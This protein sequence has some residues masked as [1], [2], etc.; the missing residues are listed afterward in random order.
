MKILILGGT[1]FLGRQ[2]ARA[3]LNAGHEVT[4][5]NRGQ[6]NP[7]LFRDEA[8][9]IHGD[10]DG[11]LDVLNGRVFDACIDPSG[12]IPRHVRDSVELMKDVVD[13]YTFISSIS[14]HPTFTR[15]QDESAPLAEL[16]DETVETMDE[17]NYGGLKVLCEQ[18]AEELM[19]GRVLHVRS[20]LIIGPYDPTD[21]FSYW[22]LRV[23]RGG[24][25]VA[26]VG[27]DMP[28]QVIDARDQADWILRSISDR[29][30]G[31][32]NVT[33]AET[34]L[35]AVLDAATSVTASNSSPVWMSAEF[36]LENDVTPWVDLPV[37]LPEEAKAM[38]QVSIER[39]S[40]EGLTTRPLDDTIRDLLDWHHGD[41]DK[42]ALGLKA[43]KESE[44]LAKWANTN[45]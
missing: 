9:I 4:L 38:M 8:E 33:G 41:P 6:T 13:H 27:P 5:F 43:D 36:L 2:I 24:D 44:L 11:G 40:A 7:D 39:A 30:T 45:Q 19:P 42:M 22:P 28:V 10:R 16:E 12:Y 3:C 32:F 20:G 15:G 14:V 26:P 35:G 34:N 29:T 23:A 17:Q 31:I 18:A 21:R 1:Q 25:Y 37:W